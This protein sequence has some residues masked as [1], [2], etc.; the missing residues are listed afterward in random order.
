MLL[1]DFPPHTSSLRDYSTPPPPPRNII[2]IEDCQDKGE[3]PKCYW[4]SDVGSPD[5][6][7]GF[8]KTEHIWKLPELGVPSLLGS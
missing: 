4:W 3:H 7:A 2:F 5:T 1:W 6:S 8:R